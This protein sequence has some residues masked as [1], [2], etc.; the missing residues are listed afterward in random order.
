MSYKRKFSIFVSST[1]EDLKEERQEILGVALENDFIPVGM[2]Q[3]HAAPASQWD[4]ITKMI[5]ECDFY[6]LI[7]G[8][9]YG[10]IDETTNISY[11]EKEY[12]YA[13]T[14][15]IPILAF[16]KKPDKI[17]GDK[18][19]REN[20]GIKQEKLNA[21][22]DKVKNDGNTVDFFEDVRDL[23]YRVS[24]SLKKSL[25]YAGENGGWVRYSD[26]RMIVNE[27]VEN[28]NKLNEEANKKQASVLEGMQAMVSQ[29]AERLSEIE[30]NRLAWGEIPTV[31]E[32]DIRKMFVEGETLHLD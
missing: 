13:K 5:D 24:S 14:N 22:R 3:F 10:S 31:S 2:E 4:V 12:N 17:T 9:C 6:L 15:N 23:K 30:N 19:D 18:M 26:V 20:L 7:I 16:I 8:G 11:T 29:M 27:N 32:D 28:V 25:D 1:Y 21:F